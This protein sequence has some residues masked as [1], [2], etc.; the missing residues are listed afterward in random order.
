MVMDTIIVKPRNQE[1]LIRVSTMLRQMDI[2][3][4]VVSTEKERKKKAKQ[5]FLDSLPGRL[6]E[7]EL[8]MQGKIELQSWD[9]LVKEI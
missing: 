9:E 6:K 7:V 8:H 4:K 3:S 2:R 5:E 1:E